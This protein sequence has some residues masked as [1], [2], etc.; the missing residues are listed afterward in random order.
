MASKMM[1]NYHIFDWGAAAAVSAAW[2][3]DGSH[4][5][6][7]FKCSHQAH[8]APGNVAGSSD[9]IFNDYSNEDKMIN[10]ILFHCFTYKI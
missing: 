10:D 1:I 8:R 5:V 9:S 4:R 3:I 7:V 6:I 2:C